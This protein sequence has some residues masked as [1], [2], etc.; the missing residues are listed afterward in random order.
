MLL[1]CFFFLVGCV[2]SGCMMLKIEQAL[3]YDWLFWFLIWA[4][5]CCYF[6]NRW[7]EVWEFWWM[8]VDWLIWLSYFIFKQGMRYILWSELVSFETRAR[9]IRSD[10]FE[11]S[12]RWRKPSI[13][14]LG[15]CKSVPRSHCCNVM[16]RFYDAF[17]WVISMCM[18]CE[19]FGLIV[20][21]R[22]FRVLA[23][24]EGSIRK[25]LKFPELNKR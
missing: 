2:G 22:L 11:S 1:R 10:H 21:V 4:C 12:R 19:H 23:V 3:Q 8:I 5:C 14:L 13:K 24:R 15:T 17:H 20:F 18:F 6:D 25:Y 7:M 16:G 9:P